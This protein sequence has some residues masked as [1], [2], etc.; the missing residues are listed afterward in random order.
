MPTA[1]LLFQLAIL[2]CVPLTAAHAEH[3]DTVLTQGVWSGLGHPVFG[4][5]MVVALMA[6]VIGAFW[7]ELRLVVLA[8]MAVSLLATLA[9]VDADASLH[10]SSLTLVFLC[11][12]L[13]LALNY[14]RRMLASRSLRPILVTPGRALEGGLVAACAVTVFLTESMA[15]VTLRI[16]AA[17]AFATVVVALLLTFLCY[18]QTRWR[19]ALILHFAWLAFAVL[20]VVSHVSPAD[21]TM[22]VHGLKLASTAGVLLL[23]LAYIDEQ[24]LLGQRFSQGFDL[25]LASDGHSAARARVER[26]RRDFAEDVA[27]LVD[28]LDP[29]LYE[30]SIMGRFLD[31]LSNMVP[32]AAAAVAVSHRG[33]VRL[34][35][36]AHSPVREEF[37]SILATREE[38]LQSV[39]LS[40][41]A[42]VIHSDD[43]GVSTVPSAASCLGIVP[44]RAPRNEWAGV[45]LARSG[46]LEFGLDELE[47]VSD[48]AHQA[49]DAI[50]SAQKF[51]RV[52]R[53][54]E[55]DALTGVFNRGAAMARG[56]R[57][58][59]KHRSL[60]AP[61][62]ILFIDI[63]HFKAVNDRFGHSAG[64]RALKDVARL[65]GDCLREN[66]F[67]GRYG[68]EEF[69]A[70][71]PG[72][73]AAEAEIVAERIRAAIEAAD[74]R[75]D[76]QRIKVTVSV[77]IAELSDKFTDLDTMLRAADRALYRAKREGRNRVVHHRYMLR[78]DRVTRHL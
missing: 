29:D 31:Y 21:S 49:Y 20:T 44:V 28:E 7:N 50:R 16:V 14:T 36:S 69:L 63:D 47:L 26:S 32:V 19:P 43:L 6:F 75:Y 74:I 2:A 38:L 57:A 54:A 72:T 15:P 66:D 12:T 37:E 34:V 40:D 78:G 52:K 22:A 55:T 59:R 48:F 27:K 68:G 11:A 58:F 1:R 18:R 51:R 67:L 73:S 25:R 61:L 24:M 42:A 4:A 8:G 65:C 46:E 5:L 71:L 35:V 33:D 39:C 23:S 56:Q 9:F 30:E 17:V 13:F 10:V 76:D 70:V 64:D 41:R 60:G 62:A 45:L 77:G 53:E 3:A